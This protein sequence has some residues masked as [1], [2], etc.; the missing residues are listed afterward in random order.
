MAAGESEAMA[1]SVELEASWLAKPDIVAKCMPSK[2]WALAHVDIRPT[3]WAKARPASPQSGPHS[4]LALIVK[5]GPLSPLGGPFSRPPVHC[6]LP[7]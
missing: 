3:M 1:L 7:L 2:R 6:A 4:S 5:Q